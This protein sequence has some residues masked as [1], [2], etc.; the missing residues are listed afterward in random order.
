MTLETSKCKYLDNQRA[1]LKEN[2]Y[3]CTRHDLPRFPFEQRTRGGLRVFRPLYI[4]L[5]KDLEEKYD[6]YWKLNTYR[7]FKS[8]RDIIPFCFPAI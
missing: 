3:I 1:F 5:I 6:I 2:F 8:L 7:L 4:I